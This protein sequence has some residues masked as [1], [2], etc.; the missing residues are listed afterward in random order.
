MRTPH[1]IQVGTPYEDV[2][3]LINDNFEKSVQDASD[4]GASLSTTVDVSIGSVAAGATFNQ[5]IYVLNPGLTNASPYINVMAHANG[6]L[7]AVPMVDIYVDTRTAA[8]LFPTG[9]SLTTNQ[10][11]LNVNAMLTKT[12]SGPGIASITISGR[13]SDASA[14]VYYATVQIAYFPEKTN[15]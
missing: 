4:L 9:S 1:R 14:H 5:V 6:L 15:G 10:L 11:A 8:Y 7:A 12:T 13:N 2:L 3:S